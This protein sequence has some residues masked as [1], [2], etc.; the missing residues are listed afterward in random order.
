MLIDVFQSKN[1]TPTARSLS[2]T[3]H[4]IS[5]PQDEQLW[6]PLAKEGFPIYSHELIL[7]AAFQQFVHWDREDMQVKGST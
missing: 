7:S 3:R 2:S 4:I 5:C 6:R 1:A